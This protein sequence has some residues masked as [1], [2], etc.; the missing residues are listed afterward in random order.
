MQFV[1][2]NSGGLKVEGRWGGD[3]YGIGFPG[4]AGLELAHACYVLP[5]LGEIRN[6]KSEIRNQLALTTIWLLALVYAGYSICALRLECSV[7]GKCKGECRSSQVFKAWV[8][9]VWN[10]RDRV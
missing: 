9:S 8:D 7:I 2:A 10:A 5:L 6:Q 4:W 1:F 3:R